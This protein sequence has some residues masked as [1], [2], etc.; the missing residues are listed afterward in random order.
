MGILSD[1]IWQRRKTRLRKVECICPNDFA[2]EY[3]PV[4]QNMETFM[5][6]VESMLSHFSWPDS[7]T[8][9]RMLDISWEVKNATW[10]YT[11][12]PTLNFMGNGFNWIQQHL[13]IMLR[14]YYIVYFHEMKWHI[15]YKQYHAYIKIK[16]LKVLD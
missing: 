10:I 7:F 6:L 16:F 12:V 2:S 14:Y 11:D 5:C 8:L 4:R 3:Y 1:H 13:C 15:Q 9:A